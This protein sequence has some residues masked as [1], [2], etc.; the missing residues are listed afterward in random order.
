MAGIGI[1]LLLGAGLFIACGFIMPYAQLTPEQMAK[2]HELEKELPGSV[3]AVFLT[4]GTAIALAGIYHLILGYFVR[5]GR[6]GAIY[7]AIVTSMIAIGFCLL[8]TMGII[9]MGGADAIGGLC[10]LVVIGALFVWL[11]MWLFQAL[12]GAGSIAVAAQMQAQYWQMR[13]QQQGYAQ[14]PG[15]VPPPPPVLIPPPPGVLAPPPEP[16]S[17]EPTGWAYAAQTPPAPPRA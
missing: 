16:P 10:F 4:V 8:Y 7:T 12:R 14:V 17:P 5:R 3:T 11:I 9:M 6:R 15:A 13:Q 1:L 2:Y